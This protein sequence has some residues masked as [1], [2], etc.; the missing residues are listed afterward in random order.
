MKKPQ[1]L[2]QVILLFSAALLFPIF[3]FKAN[4]VT[5]GSVVINPEG[6][7]AEPDGGFGDTEITIT[8]KDIKNVDSK[9][10]VIESITGV[11]E[12]SDLF[13][14]DTIKNLQQTGLNIELEPN[15]MIDY[16]WTVTIPGE[17][18]EEL[19]GGFEG[20]DI[21]FDVDNIN[22]S[23]K[24]VPEPTSTLSLL[25]LGTLGAASTLKPKLKPRR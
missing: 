22:F 25:A 17:T 10:I 7:E 18:L 11:L 6:V 2:F 23:S 19:Q 24:R 21:S 14:D 1:S 13:D 5:F 16:N 9:D 3:V 4:A 8:I 15:Q 12:E 20:E